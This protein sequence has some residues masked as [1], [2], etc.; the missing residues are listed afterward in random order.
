MIPLASKSCT[1][2]A[3][4]DWNRDKTCPKSVF[5]W[6][7][8]SAVAKAGRFEYIFVILEGWGWTSFET[9]DELG[10]RLEN[11]TR[12]KDTVWR[13]IDCAAWLQRVLY[14]F[15]LSFFLSGEEEKN[16]N[17][18]GE[19]LFQNRSLRN[20]SRFLSHFFSSLDHYLVLGDSTPSI[21]INAWPPRVIVYNFEGNVSRG[22]MYNWYL[23]RNWRKM[24]HPTKW[25]VGQ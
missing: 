8:K 10:G 15:F 21:L 17:F 3:A 4:L 7:I 24:A 18:C 14:C 9:G 16:S 12:E 19:M 20:Q 11:R 13:V 5:I 1:V 23:R 25:I 6:W 22:G 2:T